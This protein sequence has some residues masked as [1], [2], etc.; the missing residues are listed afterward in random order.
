MTSSVALEG[1][2]KQVSVELHT[3]G[4]GIKTG[5]FPSPRVWFAHSD[6]FAR[7]DPEAGVLEIKERRPRL[8]GVSQHCMWLDLPQ[9]YREQRID[10]VN[11]RVP[12]YTEVNGL[13]VGHLYAETRASA[14]VLSVHIG[15]A[16]LV[17]S[18]KGDIMV[19]GVYAPEVADPRRQPSAEFAA[20]TGMVSVGESTGSWRLTGREVFAEGARGAQQVTL[21]TPISRP[22]HQA[23]G[24]VIG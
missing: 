24:L 8:P 18:V 3:T 23:P 4:F 21:L 22:A 1:G 19:S 5:D 7:Y 9:G 15:R 14:L 13:T 10:D 17:K 16:C 11:I 12:G 2:I 6:A 20:L